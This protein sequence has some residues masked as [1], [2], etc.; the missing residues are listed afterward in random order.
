MTMAPKSDAAAIP[1]AIAIA[2]A[3]GNGDLL[4][5]C[6]REVAALP[7]FG[8][9]DEADLLRDVAAR[10]GE[11]I[12]PASERVVRAMKHV[13]ELPALR[14]SWDHMAAT[15]EEHFD[16]ASQRTPAQQLMELELSIA[17]VEC[18]TRVVELDLALAG[19]A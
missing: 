16:T 8:A 5:L 7:D 15:M 1:S 19:H 12:E 4:A 6:Q 3:R 9:G 14:A 2:S 10:A 13:G 17:L 11:R 18:W